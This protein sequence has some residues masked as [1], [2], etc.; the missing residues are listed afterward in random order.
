MLIHQI[1][2]AYTLTS[3]IIAF[4][5]YSTYAILVIEKDRQSE[6]VSCTNN[7]SSSSALVSMMKQVMC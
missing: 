1:K 4:V 2:N 6:P 7:A 5:K 3:S